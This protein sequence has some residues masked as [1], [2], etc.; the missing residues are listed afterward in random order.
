MP[1]YAEKD[2][3]IMVLHQENKGVSAARNLGIQNASGEY[4][5]FVDSDDS[6]PQNYYEIML[7]AQ[8]QY[9]SN[10]HITTGVELRDGGKAKGY[11]TF[12]N[13]GKA[14]IL[15]KNL[16]ELLRTLLMHSIWN[17]LYDHEVLLET[18]L[19]FQEEINFGEDFLFNIEYL[20]YKYPEKIVVLN[21]LFYYYNQ[22]AGETLSQK[23]NSNY[24]RYN[25][26]T[27]VKLAELC[28]RLKLTQQEWDIVIEMYW[29][30]C[31]LAIQ[32]IMSDKNSDSFWKKMKQIGKILSTASVQKVI[33]LRKNKFHFVSYWFYRMRL[34]LPIYIKNAIVK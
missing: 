28:R 33:K 13:Q 5:A 4:I 9:G 1:G 29:G 15:L 16:P 24:F 6:I 27:Y 19:M 2:S 17:Q 12:T 10:K 20:G 14:E 25:Q 23:Y 21:E 7:S 22:D 34:Y 3:R 18:G 26:F 8:E 31:N 32:M 11:R 30:I